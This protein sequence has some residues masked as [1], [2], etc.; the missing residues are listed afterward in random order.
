M[1]FFLAV[2]LFFVR[3][4][5]NTERLYCLVRLYL[6]HRTNF[7]KS[8]FVATLKMDDRRDKWH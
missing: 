6:G 4:L 7:E 8:E 1:T 2:F 3:F 5:K